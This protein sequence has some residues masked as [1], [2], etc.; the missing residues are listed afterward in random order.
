MCIDSDYRFAAVMI[1]V[2]AAQK[3]QKGN[4][5]GF[6]PNVVTMPIMCMLPLE[7]I[8]EAFQVYHSQMLNVRAGS[9]AHLRCNSRLRTDFLPRFVNSLLRFDHRKCVR[10]Q[11]R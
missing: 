2:Y 6:S 9:A 10:M 4:E 8:S 1:L 5:T 3:S 11:R 7:L